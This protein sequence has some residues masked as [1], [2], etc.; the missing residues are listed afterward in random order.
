MTNW[1]PTVNFEAFSLT[2]REQSFK[3]KYVVEFTN[4][5][6]KKKMKIRL[7]LMGKFRVCIVVHFGDFAIKCLREFKKVREIVEACLDGAQLEPFERTK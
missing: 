5:K 3:I 7:Y 1:T 4:N 2:F 6:K